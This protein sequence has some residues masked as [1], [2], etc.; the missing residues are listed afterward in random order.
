MIYVTLF[1]EFFKIG[2]F[3]V[4]GG[5]AT[6]PFL[7]DLSEKYGW[8]TL[9]ELANYIAIAESTPG[10]I[11]INVATFAGYTVAGIAGS[12][13]ATFALVLPGFVIIFIISHMLTRFSTNRYVEAA[14]SGLRPAV[15]AMIISALI[16]LAHTSLLINP[17]LGLTFA[18][19][20]VK[21]VF[22]FVAI[23]AVISIKKFAKLHP[24][25]LLSLSGLAGIL[26]IKL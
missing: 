13:I 16:S 12:I 24:I 18:N 6:L 26:L 9:T 15:A 3:S 4:G 20:S 5:L 2:L 19:I 23:F 17:P 25:V 1:L 11:G 8:Y 21:H 22:I 7:A 10:P 14:F